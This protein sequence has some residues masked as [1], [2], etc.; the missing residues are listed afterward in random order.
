MS[1][2]TL[3]CVQK[4]VSWAQPESGQQASILHLQYVGKSHKTTP[5]DEGT[6][7]KILRNKEQY[8]RQQGTTGGQ[9]REN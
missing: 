5:G 7:H 3:V 6:T 4:K 9:L 2:E 8:Y 1:P